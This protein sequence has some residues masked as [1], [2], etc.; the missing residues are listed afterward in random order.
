MKLYEYRDDE[1]HI[2]ME[3]YFNENDQLIFEGYD[4]G[5]K[6]EKYWGDSDYEYSYTI[7][8]EEVQKLFKILKVNTG[9]QGA[10]L[11]EIKKRF[12]GNDAYSKFGKFMNENGIRYKAFTWY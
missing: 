10:L 6:V 2:S 4:I 1:I 7:D 3:L 8:P 9:D 11:L 5:V 12:N